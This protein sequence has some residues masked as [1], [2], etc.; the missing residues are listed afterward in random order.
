MHSQHVAVALLAITG[1]T[2]CSI[3]SSTRVVAE[4][5]PIEPPVHQ[6][7]HRLGVNGDVDQGDSHQ[8]EPGTYW[9]LRIKDVDSTND[10]A[11]EGTNA[12]KNPRIDKPQA[13]I[14]GLVVSVTENKIV[15][16]DAISISATTTHEVGIPATSKHKRF[17]A[18][19]PRL[20]KQSGIG[21]K[22][23]PIPGEVT[24][25][26]DTIS[27]YEPVDGTHWN[28]IQQSGQWFERIG[29]DFDFNADS[30]T[31]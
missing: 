6:I 14:A 17:P 23:I 24:V 4:E 3:T 26:C 1:L 15:L 11:S 27:H 8:V 31:D 22:T 19:S 7:V 29:I 28:R 9:R 18:F 30:P 12:P 20:F 13:S 2:G 25:E 10:L 21:Y 16:K 5:A